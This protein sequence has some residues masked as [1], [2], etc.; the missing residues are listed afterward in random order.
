MNI[1]C[2]S[3]YYRC[4]EKSLEQFKLEAD[5]QDEMER[6]C[7]EFP[8]YGYR[9]VTKQL[10]RQGWTV[11]HKRV[12]R[13]MRENDLICRVRRRGVRTTDSDHSYSVFP[14][15]IKDLFIVS[16]NEV[17]VSDITYIRISTAF[18]YL[19]VILDLYSR[20]VIGYY[21]SRH[22]DTNLALS[23]LRMAIRGRNPAPG[24]IHHSD[25]GVQYASSE[26]VKELQRYGFQISMA[27]KGD[28]YE[29]AVC[30]SFI[31]TLKDEEVYLWEYKS[32]EDAGQRITHFI[33]DVYNEKRLHSSLG[34]C[35]P[36][37]FEE[38]LMENQKL[39]VAC[40]ITLT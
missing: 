30:E 10:Q 5:L 8:R 6:I 34:Y 22:I 11:N 14:N 4:K 2:S 23:A 9:R 39:T 12:L 25:Q 40:Q 32:I 13:M 29:N 36:N 38:L 16:V 24:C 33:S 28:P 27:R 18:V 26:Y 1:P 37:E 19:A 17:W 7:L 3:F 35:P 21:L 20:K 31:K 15:L